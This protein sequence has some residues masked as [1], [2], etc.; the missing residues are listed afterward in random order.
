MG[1]G[2]AGRRAGAPAIH[3]QRPVHLQQLVPARP[4]Q[5]DLQWLLPGALAQRSHDPG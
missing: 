3:G 1:S 4:E 2:V 5:R